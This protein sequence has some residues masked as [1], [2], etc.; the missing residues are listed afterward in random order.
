MALAG[1][2]GGLEEWTSWGEGIVLPAAES[3]S[4]ILNL[5]LGVGRLPSVSVSHESV[6]LAKQLVFCYYLHL[7]SEVLKTGYISWIIGF[8]VFSER[9]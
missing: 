5:K 9:D 7:I 1:T 6:V 8:F 2:D 3:G 4:G